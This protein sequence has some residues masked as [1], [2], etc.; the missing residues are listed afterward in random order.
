MDFTETFARPYEYNT[1]TLLPGHLS[2]G[3]A[4]TLVL[5]EL[6]DRSSGTSTVNTFPWCQIQL[7]SIPVR[8]YT[9]CRV[10]KSSEPNDRGR[11]SLLCTTRI[12]PW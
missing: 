11:V 1:E 7:V 4:E 5:L 10:Q 2:T 12:V 9:S 8:P 6:A 3:A